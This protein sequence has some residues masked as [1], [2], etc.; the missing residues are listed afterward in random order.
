MLN[1]GKLKI[2]MKK[3]AKSATGMALKVLEHYRDAFY[4]EVSFTVNEYYT[5]KQEGTSIEKRVRIHEDKTIG[6]KHVVIL[7]GTQYD[8]GRTFT[9]VEKGVAVTYITLEKVTTT[10]GLEDDAL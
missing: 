9:T 7:G 3:P 5:A 6:N 8:V 4:G 2:Y 1:D 10:Y